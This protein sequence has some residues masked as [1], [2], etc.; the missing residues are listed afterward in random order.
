MSM[1]LCLGTNN[2]IRIADNDNIE[3]SLFVLD[4]CREEGLTIKKNVFSTPFAYEIDFNYG[5]ESIWQMTEYNEKYSPHN[6]IKAKATF[7]AFCEQLKMIIPKGD[8]CELYYCWIGEEI[9]SIEGNLE[10]NL[11]EV[12][13]QSVYIDEKFYIK[14]IHE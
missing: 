4:N 10:F 1:I 12:V 8:I 6:F 3:E 5:Y 13:H 7:N 11:N 2:E 9:D 14:F